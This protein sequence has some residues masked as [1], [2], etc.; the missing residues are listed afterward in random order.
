MAVRGPPTLFHRS[1]G[2]AVW[3]CERFL[4]HASLIRFLSAELELSQVAR[5]QVACSVTALTLGSYFIQ[6]RT[7]MVEKGQ[8]LPPGA[9]HAEAIIPLWRAQTVGGTPKAGPPQEIAGTIPV[10]V[11]T[12]ARLF[13]PVIHFVLLTLAFAALIRL[14]ALEAIRL[15]LPL[16]ACPSR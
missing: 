4:S 12:K 13:F 16:R 15:P 10:L 11:S 1:F 5:N 8:P 6:R 2:S 3:M 9:L 14:L 7:A